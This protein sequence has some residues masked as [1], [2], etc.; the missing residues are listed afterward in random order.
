[1]SSCS[2]L[3]SSLTRAAI[4]PSHVVADVFEAARVVVVDD[5]AANL[6]LL[7]RILRSA[8]VAEIHGVTDSRQAVGRCLD[9]D[10]DLVLLDLRMPEL[11]GFAVLAELQ[12]A[13][14][15]DAYLPVLMLTADHTAA[16]REGALRA[17]ATDFLTKPFDRI[18]VLLRVRNILQTR[19]LYLDV[20]RRNAELNAELARRQADERRAEDE[21]RDRVARVDDVLAHRGL[22]MVFQ[23]VADLITGAVVGAE[24]LAR[25]TPEPRRP[26]NEWFDEASSV[27]R[28]RELELAAVAA[29]LH[30]LHQL[31]SEAFLAVNVSPDTAV[32][33][34]L[35]QL[36]EEVAPARVVLELTEHTRVD[37][38][39]ALLAGLA[40]LRDRGL[41]VAVDDAGAGYAGLR[42]VLQL[43]PDILKLDID[44]IRGIDLDPAKR[45]LS[46]ALVI[47][48][49]ETGA[50]IIAEGI[51]TP[52]ELRTLRGLGVNWGQGYHLARPA[53][54][55]LADTHLDA[56]TAARHA[57]TR[58]G[59]G[60]GASW[61]READDG[62]G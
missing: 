20:Q 32:S 11:D 17:G 33:D 13:L 35:R 59:D 36:L 43:R 40:P 12:A 25:F 41:R 3:G 58:D 23:P 44:L 5:E 19:A 24:A 14:P 50:E 47:F 9:V 57:D 51:E 38:Y 4:E 6:R 30:Q 54:L 53:A 22:D 42:H 39:T 16:A 55:P 52:A 46:A 49:R 45:A 29:A 56:C 1:M 7:E 15:G 60:D 37:D 8:G 28:S 48:A 21:R 62:E 26:P 31:P 10:A 18:E 2:T 61:S 34:Q 27:G